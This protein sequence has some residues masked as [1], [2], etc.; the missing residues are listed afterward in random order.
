MLAPQGFHGTTLGARPDVYVPMTMQGFMQPGTVRKDY[1]VFENRRAYWVYLFARLKPGMT[2]E[3][4]R[5]ALQPKY[6]AIINEVEAPLQKGMSDATLALFK[7]KEIGIEAGPQGQ[8]DVITEA[9]APVSR[10]ASCTLLKTGQPSWV[11]PPLPGV[12]PPTTWV[13]YAAA[14]FA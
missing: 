14:C 5:A 4:A 12:T 6:H 10:T 7:T 11:V 1:N 9:F 8:S 2:I 3:Q 13:P